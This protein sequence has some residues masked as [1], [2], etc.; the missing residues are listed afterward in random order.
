V[1]IIFLPL[2]LLLF[3]KETVPIRR[4]FEFSY[5]SQPEI[6]GKNIPENIVVSAT[7]GSGHLKALQGVIMENDWSAIIAKDNLG[8][9]TLLLRNAATMETKEFMTYSEDDSSLMR[10]TRPF[11][12]SQHKPMEESNLVTVV[13]LYV[14]DHSGMEVDNN[15]TFLDLFIIDIRSGAVLSTIKS[16]KLAYSDVWHYRE[17]D[18]KWYYS[19]K[20]DVSEAARK[21]TARLLSSDINGDQISDLVIWVKTYRSVLASDA[22]DENDPG[23]MEFLKTNSFVREDDQLLV[24][25]FNPESNNYTSPVWNKELKPP[26]NSVWFTLP[27]VGEQEFP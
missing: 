12:V 15:C 4:T 10:S 24:M 16:Q 20:D 25:Y 22:P 26:D 1:I 7:S 19:S 9:I 2:I 27:L 13:F 11:I 21:S 23:Y 14:L 8:R 6:P 17:P 5:L 3:G 18:W